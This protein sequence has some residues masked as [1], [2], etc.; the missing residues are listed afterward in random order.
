MYGT[1]RVEELLFNYL[2]TIM[3]KGIISQN[4]KF[5]QN[6]IYVWSE[7]YSAFRSKCKQLRP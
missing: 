2:Y 7:R 5:G 4:G 6:G 3:S 1:R